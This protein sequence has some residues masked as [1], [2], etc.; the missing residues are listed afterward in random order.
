M[1][2]EDI[3]RTHN[4]D[5]AIKNQMEKMVTS[6]DSY[7]K[8]VTLGRENALRKTTVELA[9]VKP[10]DCVLEVGSGTGTLTLA[11]KRQA[12]PTGQVFGIDIIPGM[13]EAS[14]R[15][16]AQAGLEVTFQSGSIENI[17]F[18]DNKFDV[19]LCSFMIFHMSEATRKKGIAEIRRVLKPN[20]RLLV[21]DLAMPARPLPRA[22]AQV[23]FK[24]FIEHDLKELL[25]LMREAG[26]SNIEIGPA[27]FRIFG[28]PMLSFL[29]GVRPEG[30]N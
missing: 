8:K 2:Q 21:L 4:E 5:E 6:Y 7:I 10:G 30:M 24:G 12:G 11:A 20:G 27:K 14:R 16:A 15:K 13:I 25:P 19:V 28:L 18:P 17:P 3:V 22:I 26:F 1:A 9:Q 29:R 23:F